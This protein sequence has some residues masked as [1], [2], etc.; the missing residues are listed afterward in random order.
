MKVV[1]SRLAG[2]DRD[3]IFDF[4]AADNFSAAVSNDLKL[5]EIEAQL[6][7]F[8]ESGRP[9]R[10]AGTREWVVPGTPFIAVYRMERDALILLRLIHG[11][12]QWPPRGRD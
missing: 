11:A 4:I 10:V 9:G 2:R 8:P 7:R 3:E 5:A 12:Q 1:W 6:S